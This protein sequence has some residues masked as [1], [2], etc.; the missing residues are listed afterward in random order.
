[1]GLSL[2]SKIYKPMFVFRDE[3]GNPNVLYAAIVTE[4]TESIIWYA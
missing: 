2:Q 4:T 3:D 1:M